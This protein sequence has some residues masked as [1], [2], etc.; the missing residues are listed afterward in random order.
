[1]SS[2]AGGPAGSASLVP[3]GRLVP[4][5]AAARVA[6]DGRTAVGLR[7]GA[8]E[9]F[10]RARVARGVAGR[11]A[12]LRRDGADF[13][14]GEAAAASL[15]AAGRFALRRWGRLAGRL[16]STSPPVG[17]FSEEGMTQYIMAHP[18]GARTTGS[19]PGRLRAR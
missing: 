7:P 10:A 18:I 11:E 2:P 4:S 8:V 14:G 5:G 15:P 9:A 16:D 12:G 3:G 6:A 1:M 17:V 19:G 13:L